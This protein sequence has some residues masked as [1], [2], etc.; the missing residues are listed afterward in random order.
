M[1]IAFTTTHE[2][3]CGLK[4]NSMDSLLLHVANLNHG[5][6]TD[7]ATLMAMTGQS[8]CMKTTTTMECAAEAVNIPGL[9]ECPTPRC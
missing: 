3:I 2:C 4:F 1:G 6:V 9:V 7:H 8:L 5:E